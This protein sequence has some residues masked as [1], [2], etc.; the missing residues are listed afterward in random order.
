[1]INIEAEKIFSEALDDFEEKN[2][3]RAV[4]LFTTAAEHGLAKAMYNLGICYYDAL[5]VEQDWVKAAEWYEKAATLNH[6]KAQFNIGICYLHGRGVEKDEA[7]AVQWFSKAA[8]QGDVP[9]ICNLGNCYYHGIGVAKD[10]SK[11]LEYYLQA[12]NK[13]DTYAMRNLENMYPPIYTEKYYDI[14]QNKNGELLFCIRIRDG[15]PHLSEVF[16]SGGTS[17]LLR[18]RPD[19]YVWLEQIHEGVRE[20]LSEV[21]EVL[22]AEFIPAEE[23]TEA[24]KDK[25][26]IREYTVPV[27]C[28]PDTVSFES[29]EKIRRGFV[30]SEQ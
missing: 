12:A 30:G 14:L 2:Y 26:I 19:Q 16:Y 27:R 13:G 4:Y 8:E 11:A 6:A 20:R 15:E 23:K 22:F 17:G 9:A 7:K 21:G 5:G 18:R 24:D 29:I 1:M 28:L 3:A 10:N 25:G